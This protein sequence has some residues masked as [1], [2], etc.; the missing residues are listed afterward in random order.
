[1]SKAASI[2]AYKQNIFNG[3]TIILKQ[4]ESNVGAI[5]DNTSAFVPHN[6]QILPITQNNEYNTGINTINNGIITK[7]KIPNLLRINPWLVLSLKDLNTLCL[8]TI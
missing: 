8:I 7:S 3:I 4:T 1:M 6:K 2:T 5:I